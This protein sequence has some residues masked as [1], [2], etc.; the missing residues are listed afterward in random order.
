MRR[1]MLR[2]DLA[3]RQS[4]PRRNAP[5]WCGSGKKYK[6]CHLRADE[7]GKGGG[8]A[9]PLPR[10]REYWEILHSILPPPQERSEDVGQDRR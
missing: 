4:K 1:A 2:T 3:M 9:P 6:K 7:T 8:G 5:C 10:A